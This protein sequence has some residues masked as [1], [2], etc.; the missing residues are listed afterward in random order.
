MSVSYDARTAVLDVISEYAY[1]FDED[2]IDDLVELFAEDAEWSIY[3]AGSTAP[4]LIATSN[5]ERRSLLQEVRSGPI[6]QEG[7]PR[8]FQTNTVLRPLSSD[9]V[10]ARTMV[11]ATQQPYDGSPTRVLF[12]G[13]YED[14]FVMSASGWRFAL[15][16][17]RLDAKAL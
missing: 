13:V 2:R 7:M 6:N 15:R 12:T 8:H 11:A 9:R 10:A 5:Q 1:T 16:Q 4:L 14:E 17:G 3:L